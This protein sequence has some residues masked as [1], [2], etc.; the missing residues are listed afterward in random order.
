MFSQKAFHPRYY[1]NLGSVSPSV[2]NGRS[3]SSL[4][5]R[6]TI[7]FSFLRQ[8]SS[9]VTTCRPIKASCMHDLF[10][11]THAW[12]PTPLFPLTCTLGCVVYVRMGESYAYSTHVRWCVCLVA[13]LFW[14]TRRRSCA[15]AL[16]RV[17]GW[18]TVLEKRVCTRAAVNFSSYPAP[19][20]YTPDRRPWNPRVLALPVRSAV[21]PLR[22]PCHA[23][24]CKLPSC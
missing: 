12:N 7:V 24:A 11:G 4:V 6:V 22:A 20:P 9:R 5:I 3:W 1:R 8:P 10:I 18:R 23:H 16:H 13:H 14:T 19:L 2:I 21:K 17:L 15:A